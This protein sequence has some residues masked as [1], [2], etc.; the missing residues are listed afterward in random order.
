MRSKVFPFVHMVC[1]SLGIIVFP[2]F[3]L[4]SLTIIML[5]FLIFLRSTSILRLW[6]NFSLIIFSCVFLYDTLL[7]YN[8]RLVIFAVLMC[9]YQFIYQYISL[10][11]I[12]VPVVS[13]IALIKLLLTK[14]MIHPLLLIPL[15]LRKAVCFGNFNLTYLGTLVSIKMAI[16][17]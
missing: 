13:I 8:M 4:R 2:S 10:V 3:P 14:T 15:N 6:Q 16:S 12:S 9:I 5:S 1:I 11:Y 7:Q 17:G